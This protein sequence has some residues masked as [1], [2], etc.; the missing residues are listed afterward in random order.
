MQYLPSLVI[1]HSGCSPSEFQK[2]IIRNNYAQWKC[3]KN[4]VL[5]QST[6]NNFY[7]YL[8]TLSSVFSSQKFLFSQHNYILMAHPTTHTHTHTYSRQVPGFIVGS[9]TTWRRWPWSVLA[10]TSSPTFRRTSFSTF[11]TMSWTSTATT[12]Y[13]QRT[14][15]G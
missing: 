11:S 5:Q 6:T 12:S 4:K 3:P 9:A 7:P 1:T 10:G 15:T 2:C 13:L 14:L 8:F